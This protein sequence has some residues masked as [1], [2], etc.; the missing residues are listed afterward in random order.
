[1]NLEF[2]ILIGIFMITLAQ[3]QRLRTLNAQQ[4]ADYEAKLAA[5]QEL[6][7][8]LTNAAA[9]ST[10]VQAELDAFEMELT[11]TPAVTATSD[12]PTTA[13]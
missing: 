8:N 13:S 2:I 7:T 11:P 5:Q 6:I 9:D 3:V 1:M 10:A 12:A 4:K